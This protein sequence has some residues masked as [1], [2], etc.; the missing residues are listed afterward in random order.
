MITPASLEQMKARLDIYQVVS[1]YVTLKRAGSKWKGLSPFSQ[2][3]TPSF[4]VD[5]DK[6]VFYCFSTQKGGDSIRFVMEKENLEF[7]DA[8]EHLAAKFN[9]RLEYETKPGQ[10]RGS[11]IKRLLELHESACG[12]YAKMFFS[13]QEDA[14]AVRRYWTEQRQFKE[15]LAETLQM[16]YAPP[17]ASRFYEKLRKDGFDDEAMVESGLFFPRSNP[18]SKS[19]LT[20]R[21]RGRLMVP[22]R[23]INGK[24]IAF[25]GRKLAQTPTNDPSF[26]AKYVN[27]P[28]TPLFHKGSVLFGLHHARKH[29]NDQNSFVM[30]EGQ[31]DAIRCWS[32]GIDQAIAPQ[33]TAVTETQL[34]KLRNYCTRLLLFLDGDAA[35]AKAAMRVIP[36]AV[37]AG[38]DVQVI[39][40][41]GGDDPDSYLLKYGL[42]GFEKLRGTA[43]DTVP[44]LVEKLFQ[45]DDHQP[46]SI[47]R[48]MEACFEI[49]AKCPSRVAQTRMLEQISQE[50]GHSLRGVE[51]DFAKL[52]RAARKS[53]GGDEPPTN[54][55]PPKGKLTTGA[56]DL[57]HLLLHYDDL[58]KLARNETSDH[59]FMETDDVY[60]RLLSRVCAEIYENTEWIP[61]QS[62]AS[63]SDVP[64][65]QDLLYS[66][67]MKEPDYDDPVA[68]YKN[69]M[70]SLECKALRN[71]IKQIDSEIHRFS[72]MPGETERVDRLMVDKINL[73]RKLAELLRRESA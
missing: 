39:A 47:A 56:Q 23:D 5:P 24:V 22:I 46:S 17:D 16:G 30:V 35:G 66:L 34:Q 55:A 32:V 40:L 2:E 67:L 29:V 21:F 71:R 26:E 45:K 42:D 73:Q 1:D 58:R 15:E 4:Y 70:L 8:V 59:M 10:V 64:D 7:I 18:L 36:M 68:I 54:P 57:L 28:A 61:E 62:I 63:L 33:G 19:P 72:R 31:L 13:Q 43:S 37:A 9:F 11:G 41:S 20:A 53:E 52:Q 48:S 49:V 65:E 14:V 44:F 27:S 25:S 50:T 6:G 51:E 69:C 60:S 38:V 3:K 12:Y